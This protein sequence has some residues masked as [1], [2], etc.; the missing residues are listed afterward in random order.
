MYVELLAIELEGGGVDAVPQPRWFGAVVEDV[1]QMRPA[2]PALDLGT[3]HEQTVV[4]HLLH[5]LFL[6]WGPETWPARAGVELG[7]RAKK[8]LPADD[9]N[10]DTAFVVVPVF[11][12]EG[13]LRSLV[14]ADVVL[15]WREALT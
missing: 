6:D 13:A 8:L 3:P 7:P 1:P 4:G 12:G 15:Q 10:V 5:A 11:S 2:V 9:T 14:K